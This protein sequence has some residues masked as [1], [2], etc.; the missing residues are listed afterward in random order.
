MLN[1]ARDRLSALA[2][3]AE[4]VGI[5]SMLARLALGADIVLLMNI[6]QHSHDINT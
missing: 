1:S 2:E 3:A 4:A 5:I 6:Y